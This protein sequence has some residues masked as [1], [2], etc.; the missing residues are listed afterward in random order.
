MKFVQSRDGRPRATLNIKFRV[1]VSELHQAAAMIVWDILVES[2]GL[3]E[4]DE[5][6]EA[7]EVQ[8]AVL[9]RSAIERKVREQLRAYGGAGVTMEDEYLDICYRVTEPVINRLYPD[10]IAAWA[11]AKEAE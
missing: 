4:Y 1:G 11:K 7:A 8:A 6:E 10:L 3:S 5:Y 2:G 9:S